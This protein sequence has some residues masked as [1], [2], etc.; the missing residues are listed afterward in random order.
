[1]LNDGPILKAA[2]ERNIVNAGG[3]EFIIPEKY[4]SMARAIL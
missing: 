4:F 2:A 3:D 1:M